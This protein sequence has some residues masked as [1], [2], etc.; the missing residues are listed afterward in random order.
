MT[1]VTH[2]SRAVGNRVYSC[3]ESCV[4]GSLVV[5]ELHVLD[6]FM[7]MNKMEKK[8]VYAMYILGAGWPFIKIIV[9]CVVQI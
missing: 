4:A 3:R 2:P 7:A 8:N 6:L 1:T 9:G 5:E